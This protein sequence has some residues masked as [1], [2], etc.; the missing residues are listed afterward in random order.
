MC[1]GRSPLRLLSQGRALSDRRE[2]RLSLLG[3]GSGVLPLAPPLAMRAFSS[4]LSNIESAV[5]F[6]KQ[7]KRGAPVPSWHGGL[8][9][10]NAPVSEG[11]LHFVVVFVFHSFFSLIISSI[12]SSLLYDE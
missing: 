11:S 6:L 5:L 8:P 2:W 1:A 4:F 10:L 7:A 9:H 3:R 12:C